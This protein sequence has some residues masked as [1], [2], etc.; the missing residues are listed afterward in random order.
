[1]QGISFMKKYL[2]IFSLMTSQFVCGM[3][4][5]V[6]QLSSFTINPEEII[7]SYHNGL[8]KHF[9]SHNLQHID[10]QG[11]RFI[12]DNESGFLYETN[13]W[14]KKVEQNNREIEKK[15]LNLKYTINNHRIS[16]FNTETQKQVDCI[17]VDQGQLDLKEEDAVMHIVKRNRESVVAA[18]WMLT[19][20]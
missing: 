16:F 6:N 15:N 20:Q 10:D 17:L 8:V 7:T 12:Y 13:D 1:M 14:K 9:Y 5:L 18:Y 3:N 19:R 11:C 2:I 4:H